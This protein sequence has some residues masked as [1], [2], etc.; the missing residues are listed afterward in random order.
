[1]TALQ[2]R[3]TLEKL[4]LSQVQAAAFLGVDPRTSRRWALD[5]AT[6]PIAVAKLLRLMAARHIRPEEV[7]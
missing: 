1:V 3:R 2:Y 4:G 6:V 7:A 5:E